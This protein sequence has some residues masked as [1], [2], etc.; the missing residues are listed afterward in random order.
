MN[1]QAPVHAADD[2]WLTVLRH[3]FSAW[4]GARPFWAGLLTLLGGVPII[5]FPFADIRLANVTLAMA[6][7]S[8]SVSLIIGVLLITL[9]FALWFQQGIRVFAGVA[10]ILLSLVSIPKSNLGGFFIGF[11]TAMIGG[12]L[13]LAWAPA[14]PA[15]EDATAGDEQVE[16]TDKAR[17]AMAGNPF[18]IPAPRE[19]ETAYA[20]ET[21]AHADGGRNSAG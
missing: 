4:R 8:G 15:D 14:A 16:D 9:G 17:A 11:L 10:A 21:T 2:H 19:T 18:G 20:T 12:A 3:R 1:P 13:A 6:T 7:T 5:Y